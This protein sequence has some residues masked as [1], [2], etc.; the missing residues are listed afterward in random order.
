MSVDL[1]NNFIAALGYSQQMRDKYLTQFYKQYSLEGRYVFVDK[2]ACSTMLQKELAVDT[3]MQS[4][5][6]GSICI[7]EKIEQRFT[8]NFALETDSCTVPGRLRGGWM[9]YAEADYLLYAFEQRIF[10]SAI[11]LDVYLIN[12][13]KLRSWFWNIEEAK[14]ERFKPHVMDTLNRTRIKIVPIDDVRREVGLSRYTC[15]ETMCRKAA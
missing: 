4:Q 13:P 9:R 15:T 12:F 8:G 5:K 11:G 14:P 7:E 1:A 2:S 3:I 10:D 6:G